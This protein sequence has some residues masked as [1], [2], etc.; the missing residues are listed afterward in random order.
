MLVT[1]QACFVSV[2][3]GAVF[4]KED[5]ADRGARF[6]LKSACSRYISRSIFVVILTVYAMELTARRVGVTDDV[7]RGEVGRQ[8]IP[9]RRF[10]GE[11]GEG[12]K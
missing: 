6:K 12:S 1:L 9:W 10:V 8:I 3:D 11:G 4:G 7:T 5:E 2:R